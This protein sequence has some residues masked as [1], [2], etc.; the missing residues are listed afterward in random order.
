MVSAVF[1]VAVPIACLAFGT[2]LILWIR[3]PLSVVG[4]AQ[5][6]LAYALVPLVVTDSVMEIVGADRPRSLEMAGTV[7]GVII[8][9][10]LLQLAFWSKLLFKI[11]Q[12]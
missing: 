10:W 3:W 1:G 5:I 8:V 9:L 2:G 4:Y 11:P 7:G 6:L 12:R